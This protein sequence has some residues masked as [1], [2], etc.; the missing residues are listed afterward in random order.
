V[1][2]GEMDREIIDNYNSVVTDA[3]TVYILGDVTFKKFSEVAPILKNLKGTKRLIL[4]NHD[5][6][7]RNNGEVKKYFASASDILE[8]N[9]GGRKVELCHYPML[10]W[11]GLFRGALHI[12]GHI[13]N[14]ISDPGLELLEELNA[15]NAGVDVNG[16]KPVTL[17]QLAE[18]KRK[19]Y[20][21]IHAGIDPKQPV[22]G[23]DFEM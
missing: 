2:A 9:D 8:V 5:K 11:E 15:Y 17:E 21:D 1:D 19:F 23:T 10:S 20:A 7:F 4:G 22:M 6:G 16:F 18:N 14:S 13:H 3:D 12:Y